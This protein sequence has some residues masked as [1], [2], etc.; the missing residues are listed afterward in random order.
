MFFLHWVPL[1]FLTYFIIN[2][3]YISLSFLKIVEIY[4]LD[5]LVRKGAG[6]ETMI[7][8]SLKDDQ[9]VRFVSM[10]SF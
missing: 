7:L 3:N 10:I 4:N 1:T 9:N 2:E 6:R 8:F 5:V